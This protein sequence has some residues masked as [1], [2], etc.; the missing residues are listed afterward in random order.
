MRKIILALYCFLVVTL[1]II[2]CRSSN[3]QDHASWEVYG[4]SK[5]NIH[6]SSLTQIDTSNVSQLAVAWI[7]H[8]GDAGDMTQMQVNPIIVD[9]ILYAV[10]PKLKLIALD[11]ATGEKKWMFNPA[12][13]LN[14]KTRFNFSMNVCRGVTYYA[15]GK[16]DKRIFYAAGPRLFC[17]N[18]ITGMLVTSF[19]DSGTIDLHNDLGREVK[20]LY[21]ATTSP[22]IIY[23]DLIIIGT[24]VSEEAAAAPGKHAHFGKVS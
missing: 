16:D 14:G 24:R 18:A 6:Y 7:Y 13:S 17:V 5:E 21:V 9:N 20:D 12:D 1:V 8:T 23:K 11:A 4:G 10:S 2:S 3:N 22:G 19:G 15:N